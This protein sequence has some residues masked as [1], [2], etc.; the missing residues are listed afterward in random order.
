MATLNN[1]E[2]GLHIAAWAQCNQLDT[3]TSA[4]TYITAWD[5]IAERYLYKMTG[6]TLYRYDTFSDNPLQIL[7]PCVGVLATTAIAMKYSSYS[8]YRCNILWA[9][10]GPTTLTCPAGTKWSLVG[11]MVRIVYGT[12]EGQENIVT[13]DSG[14]KIFDNGMATWGS[15]NTVVDSNKKWKI[16]Q[17]VGYQVRITFGTGASQ[18]CNVLYND[19][20]TITVSDTNFQQLDPYNNSPFTT[21]PA[22]GSGYVIEAS[23]LTLQNPWVVLPNTDGTLQFQ[24]GAMVSLTPNATSF[25]Q[26]QYYDVF[27]DKHFQRTNM[28]SYFA[29]AIPADF[30]IDRTGT[31]WGSFDINKLVTSATATNI[32]ST[33][34]GWTP[35]QWRNFE[36]RISSGTGLGQ[37]SEIIGNTIDTLFLKW[38]LNVNPTAGDG[39]EIWGS[40]RNYYM[41]GGTRSNIMIYNTDYDIWSSHRQ[42]DRGTA[43]NMSVAFKGQEPFGVNTAVR[44]TGGIRTINTVPTA[45]GTLYSVGDILTITTGGTLGKVRV[46]AVAPGG[47]VT[48][49]SL[50]GAWLTYTTGTGKITSGGTG[51]ACTVEIATIGDV[52]RITPVTAHNLVIGDVVTFSGA[53]EG[54]WNGNY[55]VL[56]TDAATAFDVAITA[57]ATAAA[58]ASQGVTV[59]V[60]STKNRWVNTLAGKLI[61]IQTVGIIPTTQIR[62]ITSNTAQTITLTTAITAA[63]N[64]T[65][66]YVILD[67]P[68]I[69]R[70]VQYRNPQL[71]GIGYATSG[72]ATT[73]VDTSKNRLGDQWKN[74]K[75][76]IISGTGSLVGEFVITGNTATQLNFSSI[77]VAI[78][79]TSQYEIMDTFGTA[80][81]FIATQIT[82]TT[83]NWTPGQWVGKIVMVTSGTGQIQFA[84]ITA[85]AATTLTF[86]AITT[87]D[88]NSTY[89]I[90]GM[91][92][93]G[94]TA[95]EINWLYGT[96]T[97]KGM[98]FIISRG[99]GS[100]IFD[101][102]DIT[103]DIVDVNLF[104][105]P[106]AETF[107]AGSAF[108]YDGKNTLY[109]VKQN[110]NL[111]SSLYALN[112]NNMEMDAAGQAPRPNGAALNGN[113]FEYM[114]TQWGSEC[115][116]L[117]QNTGT[118]LWKLFLSWL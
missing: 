71:A 89:T 50:F 8:G 22:A 11:N 90:L 60:D 56:G 42:L 9:T 103:T 61:Q 114:K 3:A 110:A 93:R 84:P 16:N 105:N 72:S 55:T 44:N 17:W 83:K 10:N 38:P 67:T 31:K 104:A 20:T 94:A 7:A 29:A 65:S 68:A 100:N 46:E 26:F 24:T 63:V 116:Y 88:T 66:R 57:T 92:T 33:G 32:T 79:T 74:Y 37:R 73:L 87:G 64:G 1:S 101:K 85:S 69:G 28:W 36:V 18:I 21:A 12:G 106:Y 2:K 80:T 117:A 111:F 49:I 51:S 70:D 6:Q 52:G 19:G 35:G 77:G 81:A 43:R 95:C 48:Q 4:L 5:G 115:L 54:A 97:R 108:T 99:W 47:I 78:D 15:V 30:G 62:R 96:D 53:T 39:I 27:R 59:L 45:W 86:G 23:V 91:N 41:V 118:Q 112:V 107:A 98:D 102:L 14:P 109:A 13:A 40:T 82:D 113:R 76:R 34:A 58:T 25:S 75:M